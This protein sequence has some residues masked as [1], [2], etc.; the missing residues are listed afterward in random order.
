M[1]RAVARRCLTNATGRE[2]RRMELQQVVRQ[3][4]MVRAFREAPLDR[5][6]V[7]RILT[8]GNR[9][10]LGRLPPGPMLHR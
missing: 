2:E 1:V 9:G 3:R 4:R 7:E 10:T 8:N 6:V 5:T